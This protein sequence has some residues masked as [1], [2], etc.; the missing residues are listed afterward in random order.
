M[1]Q[2]GILLGFIKAVNFID[3]QYGLHGKSAVLSG[4][5][6][7]FKYVSLA[8]CNGTEFYEFGSRSLSD[9]PG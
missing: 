4:P 7:N 5:L 3:K 6:E 1:W 9:N 2:K 8:G